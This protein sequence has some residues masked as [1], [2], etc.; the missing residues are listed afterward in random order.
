MDSNRPVS[1][2]VAA[3]AESDDAPSRPLP[4]HLVPLPGEQWGFWRWAGLRGAGFPA[5]G[6]LRLAAPR[7]AEAAD[8]VE[9]ALRALEDRRQEAM[10]VLRDGIETVAPKEGFRRSRALSRLKHGK[11][12]KAKDTSGPEIEAFLRA[13]AVAEEARQDYEKVFAEDLVVVGRELRRVAQEDP[14]RQAIA[15]Q[16][17]HALATGLDTLVRKPAEEPRNS[18]VRQHEQMV[19]SYLQRYSTKNDTIGWFGP[20]GWARFHTEGD[21]IALEP[22]DDLVEHRVVNFENWCADGVAAAILDEKTHRPWLLPRMVPFH[23]LK[24]NVFVPL[25]GEPIPLDADGLTLFRACDG[26]RSA[27]ALADALVADPA[28]GFGSRQAVL[29]RLTELADRG[30]ILWRVELPMVRRPELAL[31]QIVE[32]IE[33]E[34]LRA[35]LLETL[36][37]LESHR[38][39]IASATHASELA[40]ALETFENWFTDLTGEEA[41]RLPGKPY[42]ARTLIHEDCRRNVELDFGPQILEALGPPLSLILMSARWFTFELAQRWKARLGDAYHE[43]REQTG[44]VVLP[45]FQFFQRIRPI[46]LE[47]NASLV[48]EMAEELQAKWAEVLGLDGLDGLDGVE[49]RVERDSTTLRTR[50]EEVFAAPGPGWKHARQQCPDVLLAADSA[51]AI[52]RG[53]F[54]FVLGEIHLATNTLRTRVFAESHPDDTVLGDAMRADLPEPAVIPWLPRRRADDQVVDLIGV[55]LP[56][57]SARLDFGLFDPKDLR[58]SINLEPPSDPRA[59][60][61]L[62]GDFVVLER[63]DE[64]RIQSFDGRH[65]FGIMDFLDVA[66]SA[67]IVN[68]FRILPKLSHV[69]RVTIDRLVVQRETWRLPAV[70]LEFASAKTEAERFLGA[71]LWARALGVPRFAFGRSPYENKPFFIDF[72]SPSSIEI[73]AHITRRALAK[74]GEKVRIGLSEMAPGLDDCWL[75]DIDDNR[76]TSELRVV[77]VDLAP[78]GA[79]AGSAVSTG[80]ASEGV[81]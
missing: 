26:K 51:E 8:R 81:E 1:S 63:D 62:I 60:T 75:S 5:K 33:D 31:R 79:N 20:I 32:G 43:L 74:G 40:E 21:P 67:Q 39:A 10:A 48:T 66:F 14:F 36:D 52:A 53:D 71:R 58:V 41:T 77:A 49:R 44:E 70:G 45:L 59:E 28:V 37:V 18:R 25:G 6:V 27:V 29:D 12:P 80:P 78:G 34:T 54:H 68:S 19:T 16:N 42:A 76:F 47:A 56:P 22:G 46:L 13:R 50:V 73:F 64:L 38:T 17:R 55:N 72:N 24:G 35:P 69:P 65:D 57:T 4:S 7:S 3:A 30:M 9:S 15:W 11:A 61:A 2:T 23:F